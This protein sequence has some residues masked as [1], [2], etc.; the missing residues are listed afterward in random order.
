MKL[1]LALDSSAASQ[2]A[3]EEVAA[4][5]WPSGSEFE[6]LSVVDAGAPWITKEVIEIASKHAA[7][8]VER[9]AQRLVRAGLQAS[10]HVAVGDPKQVIV[11]RA[12]SIQADL[13]I[14]GPHGGLERFLVGSVAKAVLRTAPCSVELVRARSGELKKVLLATDGSEFSLAAAKSIAARPW[15]AGTEVRVLSAVEYHLP[16]LEASLEPAFLSPV[17]VEKLREEAMLHAQTAIRTAVEIVTGAGVQ[18]SESLSVLVENPKQ[19]IVDEARQ[20]GA[21]LIVVGSHGYRGLNRL[22][23]GGI[24]EAVATHAHCSVEVIRREAVRES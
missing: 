18:I 1:L 8:L 14:L 20:W 10:A 13:I 2:A 5:P 9:G 4:R 15:P 21:G 12:A 22:L 6:A 7:D 19:V 3:V 24:S 16:F 17:S 11:D 23:L